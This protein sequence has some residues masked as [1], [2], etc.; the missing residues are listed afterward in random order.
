VKK[1]QSAAET[2]AAMVGI[3]TTWLAEHG[4]TAS[5]DELTI[6]RALGELDGLARSSAYNAWSDPEGDHTPQ[7]R[8]QREV[9][10]AIIEEPTITATF[11]PAKVA[12]HV[13]ANT[14]GIIS[15]SGLRQEMIRVLSAVHCKKL[16]ASKKH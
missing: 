8:F 6:D 4:M 5:L 11:D 3:G 14:P 2:R 9:I 7:Q 13:L 10:R 1:R 12:E 15:R 16:A